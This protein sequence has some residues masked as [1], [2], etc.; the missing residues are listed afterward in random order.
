MKGKLTIGKMK[1]SRLSWSFVLIFVRCRFQGE[2]QG[3]NQCFLQI[4]TMLLETLPAVTTTYLSRM[5][6]AVSATSGS[7]YILAY[8]KIAKMFN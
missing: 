4:K 2:G 6:G 1:S 5:I 3:K 8:F 7:L